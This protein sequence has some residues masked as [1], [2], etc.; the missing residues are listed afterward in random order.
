MRSR[1]ESL[2]FMYRVPVLSL[3]RNGWSEFEPLIDQPFNTTHYHDWFLLNPTIASL[4][5]ELAV[6]LKFLL[7]LYFRWE[8]SQQS[9]THVHMEIGKPISLR[10]KG[11]TIILS[12]THL[13]VGQLRYKLQMHVII[14]WYTLTAVLR[15]TVH[16]C[17]WLYQ[18]RV[19]ESDDT[20]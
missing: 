18:I 12:W 5:S 17:V 7:C 2:V 1:S 20:S 11:K 8:V 16:V 19:P 4:C 6:Y 13:L 9:S 10:L 15:W 14:S 3:E